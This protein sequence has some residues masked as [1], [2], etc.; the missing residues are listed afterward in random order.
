MTW[1]FRPGWG[2]LEISLVLYGSNSASCNSGFPK[3]TGRCLDTGSNPSHPASTW[4]TAFYLKSA[5]G[6]GI[7]AWA[8]GL[9]PDA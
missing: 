9:S 1:H 8:E 2:F 7:E 6:W 4:P 5:L 3:A